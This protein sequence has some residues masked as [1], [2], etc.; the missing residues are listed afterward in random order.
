VLLRLDEHSRGIDYIA[1]R[2][3]GL[4]LGDLGMGLTNLE[5]KLLA[6]REGAGYVLTPE[7]ARVRVALEATKRG[8]AKTD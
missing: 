1:N 2:T 5:M 7:G 3:G 4:G 8:E 6:R